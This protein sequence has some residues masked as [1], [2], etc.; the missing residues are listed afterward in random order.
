MKLKLI[1]L[2]VLSFSMVQATP[3]EDDW[4]QTGHRVVAEVATQYLN[5]KAKRAILKL[6]DGAPLALV[7]T[8]ADEMKSYKKYDSYYTW[9]YINMPLD[10]DYDSYKANPEGDLY[11]GI[12]KCI[13]VLK[14]EDASIEDK[15]FHLKLLVHFIGDLH[16]P[17]H[18]GRAEDRGGN[19][20]RLKWFGRNT[21]LH[22]VWD[23]KIIEH[24]DMSYTEWA[25]N[26]PTLSWKKQKE[27][28]SSEVIDWV[29]ESQDLAKTIYNATKEGE[30]LSYLYKDLNLETI[31]DQ[32][33][34]AGVR[35]AGILNDIFG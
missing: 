27:L 22:S 25:S 4:G 2:F 32:L 35:L 24:F 8:Y 29:E 18:I 17:M 23:T 28:Q 16:Q 19:D 26:L 6:L 11:K 9:H 21:N 13:Q 7:S 15:Q 31:R 10:A 20:I 3:I 12:Q 30:K 5:K 33:I 34:K 1:L 14:D